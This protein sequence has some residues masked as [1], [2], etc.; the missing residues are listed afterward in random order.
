MGTQPGTQERP[1]SFHRIDV[2][3]AKTV[4]VFITRVFPGGMINGL[5]FKS[6]L[7]QAIIDDVLVR[8]NEASLFH[9]LHDNR[10]DGRLLNI[11]GHC[12]GHVAIALNESEYRRL[13][14][15]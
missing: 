15:F 11:G 10:L 8:K 12:D 5:V 4:A 2:N 14:S 9:G 13:L 1:K 6:P 7:G 3:F